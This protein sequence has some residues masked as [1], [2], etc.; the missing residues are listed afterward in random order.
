MT[1]YI[2]SQVYISKSFTQIICRNVD[3]LE[4]VIQREV[5][6]K[7]KNKYVILTH[8]WNLEKWYMHTKSR[9]LCLA[10]CDPMDCSPARL[11]CPWYIPGKNTG[12]DCHFLLQGDLPEPGIKPTFVMSLASVGRCFTWDTGQ[13][14]SQ[15]QAMGMQT[16]W[17]REV[18]MNTETGTYKCILPSVKQIANLHIAQEAQFGVLW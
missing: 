4:S 5:S 14:Q 11:L 6:Q 3:W 8:M 17:G 18:R 1:Q 13:E 7:E 9:K 16:Q 12:M 2:C 10:L 15:M